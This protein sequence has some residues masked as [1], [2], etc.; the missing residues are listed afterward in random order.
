M[1]FAQPL[2]DMQEYMY[3]RVEAVHQRDETFIKD[4][5]LLQWIGTEW[6]RDS[7]SK[8]LWVDL[9]KNEVRSVR[10]TFKIDTIITTDDC[11][12]DNE[13]EAVKSLGGVI[14]KIVSNK[15]GERIDTTSGIVQHKSEAGVS[16]KFIDF[17][18]DN[19]YSKAEFYK[20]LSRVL[21][22]VK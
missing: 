11:R 19:S 15:N 18:I 17:T 21:K 14:V 2:Y 7:I 9:W 1:K 20:E 12:F 13:A 4:R 8:T 10:K 3:K 6:G 16:D 5:K 22:S